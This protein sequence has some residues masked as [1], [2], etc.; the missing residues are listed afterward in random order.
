MMQVCPVCNKNLLGGNGSDEAVATPLLD[1]A[2]Q[3]ETAVEIPFA[4]LRDLVDAAELVN[5]FFG[6][7]VAGYSP[8]THPD[9]N[10]VEYLASEART[11]AQRG[12]AAMGEAVAG[13][14]I[15]FNAEYAAMAQERIAIAAGLAD[16]VI[17]AENR[18]VVELYDSCDTD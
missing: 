10:A 9:W 14:G 11:M 18:A 15:K 3:D 4:L 12:R 1:E 16:E 5:V 6:A 7:I 8:E 17:D 13:M 2:N